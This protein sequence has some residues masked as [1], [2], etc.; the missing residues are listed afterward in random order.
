MTQPP[1]HKNNRILVIDD[2]QAIHADFK[3]VLAG[4]D[5]LTAGLE[6][7]GAE[8][9]GEEQRTN[10]FV[11]FEVDSAFS[12][13]E[14]LKSVNEAVAKGRPY[15]LA[16][17][18]VRMA[19]GW[20]GIETTGRMFKNDPDIQIVICTAYSD[21]SWEKMIEKLGQSDRLVILKKPFDT[22]EVLQ[23]AHAMMEK[24]D[25][26]Q[27]A[28]ARTGELERMV[29]ERTQELQIANEHLKQEMAERVRTEE[30]LRQAQKM[31]AVGQLAGGIA[32]DF[33]NLLTVIRGYVQCLHSEMNLGA[34]VLE[35][36]REIDAAAERAAKLTSQMLMFSRKKQIRPVPMDVNELL[37][38]TGSMLQRVLGENITLDLQSAAAPLIV[39]ADPVMIEMVILN[40]S[41]NS[42][43]AMPDGG[44]LSIRAEQ[45]NITVADPGQNT[46]GRS[47]MFACLIIQD[48]GC[49]IPP[50]VLPHL[51]EPFFT[52]KDVGKGTGLGLASVYGVIKQHAGWIEVES[53]PGQGAKFKIFLPIGSATP[54]PPKR[55]PKPEIQVPNGKETI[56]LV[57]DES[58][59]RRLA[60]NVLERHGYHVLEAGSGAEALSVWS[61]HSAEVDLLMTDIIMPGGMSGH[62]L[63]AQLL[64]KKADLKILYTSGYGP[65]MVGQNFN[66]EEGVNFLAKA[67]HPDRLIR[68]IR[69]CLEKSAG[70]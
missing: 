4:S 18:D 32:H 56:L 11:T 34:N 26:Q 48:D 12:G 33:N 3:K 29:A 52:T 10:L 51:F 31:E 61:K 20:D 68:T 63:G 54:P 7:A 16:F 47:G 9:F 41:V 39:Q 37:N 49:G 55:L 6:S 57:E 13:E 2:N 40:L 35:A 69:R 22:I 36:L 64:E 53:E 43:D 46:K 58:S 44:H 8:L 14:G 67:Y 1:S 21:Y 30:A 42:R 19:P 38:R 15:A 66:L 45:V 62:V 59:L 65:D 23:L 24:W 60:K 25:L 27:K 50:E 28:R 17:V 70:P 5:P